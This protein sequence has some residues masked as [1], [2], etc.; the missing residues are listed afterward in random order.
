MGFFIT[1]LR[2]DGASRSRPATSAGQRMRLVLAGMY[3]G[4][5]A[6]SIGVMT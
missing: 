6:L 1:V 2:M 4:G 5:C 3:A